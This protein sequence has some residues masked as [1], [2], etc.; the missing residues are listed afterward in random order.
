MRKTTWADLMSDEDDED[1]FLPLASSV[2]LTTED[3]YAAPAADA[4]SS[5]FGLTMDLQGLS[6][7]P[8]SGDTNFGLLTTPQKPKR[9]FE[10]HTEDKVYVPSKLPRRDPPKLDP[11]VESPSKQPPPASP[12]RV[13]KAEAAAERLAEAARETSPDVSAEVVDDSKPREVPKRDNR[14]VLRP[15][16]PVAEAEASLSEEDWARRAV[17]RQK[18]VDLGKMTEGFAEYTRRYPVPRPGDPRTPDATL[19]TPRKNFALELKVWRIFLHQF[20]KVVA[21]AGAATVAGA[22]EGVVDAATTEPALAA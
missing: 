21:P 11:L 8:D 15:R 20:D 7:T 19:R 16:P 1:D 22:V 12:L 4:E 17:Q 18:Q 13:A 14:V 5:R 9:T 10:A 3:T 6:T 2:P